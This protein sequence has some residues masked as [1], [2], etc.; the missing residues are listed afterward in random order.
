MKGTSAK[1]LIRYDEFSEEYISI[2]GF[3]MQPLAN[4]NVIYQHD[5][6]RGIQEA[7]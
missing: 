6:D 1:V 4:T 7:T 2:I 5:T 3:K